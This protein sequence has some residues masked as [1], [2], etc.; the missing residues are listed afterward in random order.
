M[1]YRTWITAQRSGAAMLNHVRT[2]SITPEELE[3]GA[4][5]DLSRAKHLHWLARQFDRKH[6]ALAARLE[7]SVDQVDVINKYI[8]KIS[9]SIDTHVLREEF[10]R[11]APSMLLRDLR[12]FMT[13]RVREEN[14]GM[15]KPMPQ[16]RFSMGTVP[17]AHGRIHF[18]GWLSEDR[19]HM[20][21][22]RLA[23]DARALRAAH[24]SLTLLDAIGQAAINR[25]ITGSPEKKPIHE[26]CF[27]LPLEA[28]TRYFSDGRIATSDGA[29]INLSQFINEK[30][31]TFGY[32]IC[33]G[34]DAEGRPAPVSSARIQRTIQGRYFNPYQKY[35]AAIEHLSCVHPRCDIAAISCDGHHIE[36]H[37]RGG[38]TT[39]D[40]LAPLC[41]VHNR[42][43]CDVPGISSRHGRIEKDP[44]TGVPGLRRS[45][46]GK[47]EFRTH[48]KS[49]SQWALEF[50]GKQS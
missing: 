24:E 16:A 50:Y 10:I 3:A 25:L 11:R 45:K 2:H 31:S 13:R 19:A 41:R 39:Y 37:C 38:P 29:T 40:N 4:G 34:L 43:N 22:V 17:D 33:W 27:I 49:V 7:L 46:R 18:S 26:P 14:A 32:V 1:S 23:A 21:R 8:K 42:L 48:P 44:K 6:L 30:I 35:I 28:G 20:L 15:E 5:I 9:A 36:A 47:L 12:T